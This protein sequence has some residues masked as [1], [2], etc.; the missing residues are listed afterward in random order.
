MIINAI[1]QNSLY[2]IPVVNG[3]DIVRQKNPANCGK[4]K[5]E[6]NL[7]FFL[8]PARANP[9]QKICTDHP[10]NKCDCH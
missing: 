4:D 2:T 7:A 9:F 8:C 10:D 5:D 3:S 1:A 6:E